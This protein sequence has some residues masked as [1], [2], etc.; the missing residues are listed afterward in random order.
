MKQTFPENPFGNCRLPPFQ[1]PVSHKAKTITG[2]LLSVLSVFN[3]RSNWFILTNAKHPRLSL[4]Q[5][6]D[7]VS[8]VSPDSYASIENSSTADPKVDRHMHVDRVSIKGQPR[9]RWSIDGG[10]I[11]SIDQA[12]QSRISI[13]TRPRMP[14]VGAIQIIL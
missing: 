6:S 3:D 1:F 4:D 5:Q 9:C 7:I 10:S 8:R 11:K 14:L 12:Y 13:N 2:K